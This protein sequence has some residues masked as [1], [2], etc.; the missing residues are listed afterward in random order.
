KPKATE[1]IITSITCAD[2]SI[3][4]NG[5]ENPKKL[6]KNKP[7]RIVPTDIKL[8]DFKVFLIPGLNSKN[9]IGMNVAIHNSN[10]YPTSALI[11]P[12]NSTRENEKNGVGSI[13][14]YF[15]VPY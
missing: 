14:L 5:S 13:E 1:N 4:P 3:T 7:T 11:N 15:D 9:I 12:K 8:N 2:K 10:P 6:P